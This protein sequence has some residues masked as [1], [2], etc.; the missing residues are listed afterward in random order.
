MTRRRRG[1]GKNNFP[2]GHVG[3]GAECHRCELAAKLKKLAEDGKS[4]YVTNK[5]NPDKKLH[6]VWTKQQLLDESKRLLDG[7]RIS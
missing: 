7:V 1:N 6:K 5:K 4:K 3:K 2:C